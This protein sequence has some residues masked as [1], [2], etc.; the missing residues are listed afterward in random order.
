[1]SEDKHLA[2]WRARLE[3]DDE[4]A[5]TAAADEMLTA[6][7]APGF[8]Q[9]PAALALLSAAWWPVSPA[10]APRAM[11]AVLG[12]AGALK[13]DSPE[14]EDATMLLANVCRADPTLLERLID[15]TKDASPSVRRAA[16]GAVGRTDDAAV[17]AL[18]LLVQGLEDPVEEVGDAA[19]ESLAALG[20]LAPDAAAPALTRH[21][22]R[23]SGARRYLALA[24]LR[25]IMEEQ[26]RKNAPLK[27][28]GVS[29]IA[30]QALAD[31]APAVRLEA[32]ALLGISARESEA[33]DQALLRSLHDQSPEV[34][35]YAA[36][37][38]LRRNAGGDEPHQ[39]LRAL[40]SSD[41]PDERGAALTPLDGVEPAVARALKPV[42][43]AAVRDGSEE[44]K[45]LC[46]ELLN[47]L[48][49]LQLRMGPRV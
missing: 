12:A 36:V 44:V 35:A 7:T 41:E 4:A 6:L 19:L 18:P 28:D 11:D 49:V 23:S 45:P 27:L 32:A 9:K 33:E 30:L 40:L 31:E 8:K 1:M 16:L 3:G 42:L 5:R 2:D 25:G 43:E 37:A 22:A 17:R 20:T 38:L 47:G 29:G 34:A 21:A 46:R 15:A 26:F 24:G 13:L 48:E 10:L 14:L 39:T